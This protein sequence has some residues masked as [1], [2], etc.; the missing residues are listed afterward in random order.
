MGSSQLTL[1]SFNLLRLKTI[2]EQ[3]NL[4]AITFDS[5]QQQLQLQEQQEQ[6]QQLAN[7]KS[8]VTYSPDRDLKRPRVLEVLSPSKIQLT[9]QNIVTTADEDGLS[10]HSGLLSKEHLQAIANNT[11]VILSKASLDR[12]WMLSSWPLLAAVRLKSVIHFQLHQA[13]QADCIYC[14]L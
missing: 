3:R 12:K 1:S 14:W 10:P 2:A 4:A 8:R 11:T 9:L 6:Q 7:E 5:D 13:F